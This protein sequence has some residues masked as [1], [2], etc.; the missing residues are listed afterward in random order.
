M[1]NST[2]LTISLVDFSGLKQGIETL[3]K[4]QNEHLIRDCI[5]ATFTSDDEY[6]K[7]LW[8]SVIEKCFP[9]YLHLVNTVLVF[10]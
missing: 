8:F 6:Q 2:N 5:L 1:L 7:V 4:Y 10:G 9:Q 3:I